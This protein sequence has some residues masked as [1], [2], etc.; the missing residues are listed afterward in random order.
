MTIQRIE[1]YSYD[2]ITM[3]ERSH[4]EI[5]IRCVK[6]LCNALS[7]V[8]LTH[9]EIDYY[10]V[11]K[12]LWIGE[13][14]NMEKCTAYLSKIADI[15]KVKEQERINK[16]NMQELQEILDMELK[17]ICHDTKIEMFEL[18]N[19]L[20]KHMT[21]KQWERSDEIAIRLSDCAEEQDRIET[22]SLYRVYWEDTLL[23]CSICTDTFVG[24]GHNAE[25]VMGGRCCDSCNSL[26]V[27][28]KRI[29]QFL[30]Q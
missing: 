8:D 15:E 29:N 21:K 25:P 19:K 28:P 12:A 23:E 13:E 5:T 1:Q 22:Q 9:E 26:Y 14:Y 11:K 3:E 20:E 7:S 4:R 27:L 17:D 10:Q 2:V 24:V 6:R 18:V 16:E 30:N